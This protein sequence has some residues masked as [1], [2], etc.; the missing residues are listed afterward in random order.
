MKL[1]KFVH[2]G[3]YNCSMFFTDGHIKSCNF[4]KI[5]KD[6]YGFSAKDVDRCEVDECGCGLICP[7]HFIVLDLRVFQDCELIENVEN[8]KAKEL[9][10]SPFIL[11]YRIMRKILKI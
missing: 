8:E 6:R 4:K 9:P 11:I 10:V 1:K 3:N 2:H 5:F 7:S